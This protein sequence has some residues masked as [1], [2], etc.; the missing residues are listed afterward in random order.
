[1]L[2]Y[3]SNAS[4]ST[5]RSGITEVNIAHKFLYNFILKYTMAAEKI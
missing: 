5:I 1:M 4:T 3:V 2:L